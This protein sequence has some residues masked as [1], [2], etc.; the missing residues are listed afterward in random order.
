ME[1]QVVRAIPRWTTF[2][3]GGL[4]IG[5]EVARAQ[6]APSFEV[7]SVVENRSGGLTRFS[8]GL[9]PT[10][11]VQDPLPGN[12]FITNATL[13][14]IIALAYGL[15]P[16][17]EQHALSGGPTRILETRFNITAKPPDGAPASQTRSMLQTLL[18][19]RFKLRAH[20]QTQQVPVYALKLVTEGRF[21]PQLRSSPA[22]CTS[23][24]MPDA[25]QERARL[26]PKD[27]TG[28]PLCLGP[29]QNIS[30]SDTRLRYVSPLKVMLVYLQ[31]F[32]DRPLVDETGL[33]GSFEWTI[34]FSQAASLA[35]ATEQSGPSIFLAVREQLGLKLEAGPRPMDVVVIDSVEMPTPN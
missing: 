26:G 6:P 15:T 9:Q 35:P 22:D 1:G 21:G 34:S 4:L 2:A 20:R 10:F 11:Q 28:Q 5:L 14:H 3:V 23:A 19:D 31:A 27:A 7:A 17:E 30:F 25:A 33:Q 18:A 8:P 13:R 16:I 12:V 24:S 32:V 29:Y